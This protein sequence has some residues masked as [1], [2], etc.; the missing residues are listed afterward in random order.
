MSDEKSSFLQ[1]ES[2]V[3]M[4]E[5]AYCNLVLFIKNLAMEW[6][7]HIYSTQGSFPFQNYR[8]V[9]HSK[10]TGEFTHAKITLNM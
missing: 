2:A 5:N 8:G 10:I 1:N 3:Q 7:Y 6:R 9:P 4:C